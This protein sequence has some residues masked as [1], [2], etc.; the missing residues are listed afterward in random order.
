MQCR[1]GCGVVTVVLEK[2]VVWCG[3]VYGYRILP[4]HGVSMGPHPHPRHYPYPSL[5]PSSSCHAAS[6]EA[7]PAGGG[8]PSELEAAAEGAPRPNT[9]FLCGLTGPSW[10]SSPRFPGA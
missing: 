10:E 2:G 1:I 9:P 7:S 4:C 8:G 5:P 6:V 3:V